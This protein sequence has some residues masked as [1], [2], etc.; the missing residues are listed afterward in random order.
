MIG[1]GFDVGRRF[2]L[3]QSSVDPLT[4]SARKFAAVAAACK[5]CQRSA[6]TTDPVKWFHLT[7]NSGSPELT[8]KRSAVIYAAFPSKR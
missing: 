6:L 5:P 8:L 1:F 4:P 3:T 2:W 7:P